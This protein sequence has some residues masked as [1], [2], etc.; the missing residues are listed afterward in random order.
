MINLII[1]GGKTNSAEYTFWDNINKYCLNNTLN[2]IGC[3]GVENVY[4]ILL[5]ENDQV[6]IP[7]NVPTIVLIDNAGKNYAI[8]R[9]I[10]LL[11]KDSLYFYYWN[12]SSFEDLILRFPFLMKNQEEIY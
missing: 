8:I 6:S 4:S 2:I 9:E 10:K 5:G 12:M 7:S 11:C 1:E 3:Y